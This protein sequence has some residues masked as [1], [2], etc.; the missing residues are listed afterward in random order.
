MLIPQTPGKN[1]NII[2]VFTSK[3]VRD[4]SLTVATVIIVVSNAFPPQVKRIGEL[5]D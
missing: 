5:I 3:K 1:I 4:I 2:N